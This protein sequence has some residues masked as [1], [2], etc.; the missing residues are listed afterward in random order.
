MN[1]T[2][3]RSI[4]ISGDS[5]TEIK[6]F[7]ERIDRADA[8]E[9]HLIEQNEAMAGRVVAAEARAEKAEALA[10]YLD[11]K[12]RAI[13]RQLESGRCRNIAHSAL[14]RT[15]LADFLAREKTNG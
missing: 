2:T 11:H 14:D 3:R 8:V 5:L 6:N 1:P 13:T 10:R 9:A 12:L 7:V 15:D 4:A